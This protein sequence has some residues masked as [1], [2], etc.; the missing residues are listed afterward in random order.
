MN[1]E[2]EES[3]FRQTER[4]TISSVGTAVKRSLLEEGSVYVSAPT[5]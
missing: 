2:L 4:A 5:R 3:Y 1:T